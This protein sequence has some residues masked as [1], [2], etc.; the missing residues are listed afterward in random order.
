MACAASSIPCLLPLTLLQLLP[1]TQIRLAEQRI[2]ASRLGSAAFSFSGRARAVYLPYLVTFLA[3]TLLFA[4]IAA[5]VWAVIAPGIIP[6]VG[7]NSSDPRLAI[8]IQRAA[9][10]VIIGVIAFGMGVGLIGCW[11][12]ALFTRHIVGNTRLDTLPLRSTVTGRALLWL[13]VSN[14]LIAVVTLGLGLPI[15]LHRSMRFL[16]R[17]LLVSGSL[18][19]RD[20]APEHARHAT[21]RRGHVADARPRQHVLGCARAMARFFDGE[22]AAAHDVTPQLTADALLLRTADGSAIGDVAGRPD[23]RD[24]GAGF[25]RR[26][27]AGAGWATG[28]VDRHRRRPCCDASRR[29]GYGC[30]VAVHGA[31]GIGLRWSGGSVAGLVAVAFLLDATPRLAAPLVPAAWENRLGGLV[32][33]VL[34]HDR[35][36]CKGVAGQR[37]L[38]ALVARL[39]VAGGIEPVVRIAV[40]DDRM[41]NALTLPGGRVLVM[42]GLIDKAQDGAELAGV[43]AHELG[44][45][46]HRD[47]TTRLLRQLGIGFIA[48]SLG[49][50]DALANAGG[51]AQDLMTLLYSRRAEAA[52]DAAGEAYLNRA[53]LRADGLGRFFAAPGSNRGT[54]RHR[55][56]GDAPAHRGAARARDSAPPMERRHCPMR[57]GR[58]CVAC[59]TE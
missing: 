33:T 39:R 1:W 46:A 20:A 7:R 50:N 2:N 22:R 32:E 9:P 16:A 53:G 51:I 8:A 6:F 29:P 42:R 34:M 35:Q 4:A 52:A 12:S 56:A 43:I 41:V 38:E 44:H 18:G 5:V 3:I 23:R 59:A 45:V 17:N 55:A 48:A 13:Y 19:C 40:L 26:R 28:A 21:D 15:V 11:Y 30:G 24:R 36:T 58:R 31:P 10:V 49:W 37:A 57:N 27:H 25:A 47:P 54:W 14:G